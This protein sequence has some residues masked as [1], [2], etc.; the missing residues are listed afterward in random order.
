MSTSRAQGRFQL[1]EQGVRARQL[2]GEEDTM[3]RPFNPISIYRHA[4][5]GGLVAMLLGSTASAKEGETQSPDYNLPQVK[6]INQEIRQV[7]TDKQ[8][9]PSPPATDGEWCRRVYL[10][11]LGRIPSVDELRE[12]VASKEPQKKAKLVTKLLYD[13]GYAGRIRPQLDDDLDQHPDRPQRRH[14]ATTR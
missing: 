6:F 14:R 11:M 3:T 13:D 12:F 5:V 8:L 1:M 4:L 9:V 2:A 10:D 7:W